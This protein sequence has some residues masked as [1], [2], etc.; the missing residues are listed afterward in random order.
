MKRR[1]FLKAIGLGALTAP[2]V[3]PIV[4]KE[5]PYFPKSAILTDEFLDTQRYCSI[6]MR[7]DLEKIIYNISPIETAFTKSIKL[8][9]KL[10]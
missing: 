4:I 2:L 1:M 9:K 3:A 5:R 6:G 8:R 7:E 10:I